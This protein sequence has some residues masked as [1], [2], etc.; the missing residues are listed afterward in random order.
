[1]D[2]ASSLVPESTEALCAGIRRLSG[3]PLV[4]DELRRVEPARS[5]AGCELNRV[6]RR[7]WCRGTTLLPVRPLYTCETIGTLDELLVRRLHP[8]PHV[9]L[10]AHLAS[11]AH[12]AR[13]LPAGAGP[14]PV[15]GDTYRSL[16]AKLHP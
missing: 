2:G 6:D 3:R 14:V 7:D 10:D 5:A 11:L 4:P 16:Y 9:R 1:M 15:I 8:R 12:A 13:L